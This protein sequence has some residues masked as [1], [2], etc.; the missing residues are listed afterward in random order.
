MSRNTTKVKSIC[1]W[2]M[3]FSV[4]LTGFFGVSASA[5]GG[6]YNNDDS[7]YRTSLD[8]V[9]SILTAESYEGYKEKYK[10]T[11]YIVDENGNMVPK[12][13]PEI[14][15]FGEY[16]EKRDSANHIFGSLV[17]QIPEDKINDK[18]KK[19]WSSGAIEPATELNG[20]TGNF[21]L[22]GDNS[23][24]TWTITVETSSLYNIYVEYF[25][26]DFSVGDN[27]NSKSAAAERYV[28]IDGLVP[29]K[30][31]RSIKFEKKWV[32]AYPD[33]VDDKYVY[34]ENGNKVSFK[35]DSE[36][37]DELIASG[38]RPFAVDNGGNELKPEKQIVDSWNATYLFDS[39]GYSSE[40]LSFYL[41]EGTH[42][43]SL[44]AIREPLAIKCV[45]LCVADT[46]PT[47]EEYLAKYS[48][49]KYTGEAIKVQAEF[50][51]Y[52]SSDTIYAL[53]D[54]ASSYS[55]P[56]DAALI[57]LNEIGGDKW[58]YVGQWI[59]WKVTVPE[60]GLY[61]IVPRSRQK[62]YSGMYVSRAI[63]IND[64]LPFKEAGNLRFSYS[65]DWDTKSLTS[66]KVD[67]EG[68]SVETEH[69]F[70]LKA[71]ENTIRMQ[72]VL[73]DM[74]EV[75]SRVETS[76]N[77]INKYYRKILM[78]TGPEP[79]QYRDYGFEK[80]IPDVVEGLAYESD[81][82]YAVSK[83]LEKL[84]GE[85]GEHATTLDRVAL[86]CERMSEHPDKIATELSSLKDYT[87]SL[88]TWLSD[89]QNQPLD[90]DYFSIQSAEDDDPDAEPGFF[91]SL[92][93]EIKK[94]FLSFFSDYN[95]LGATGDNADAATNVNVSVWTA[96]SRD[97]AQIL[98]TLVDDK[99][100]PNYNG[101]SVDIKLVAGGTLLPATL[102]GTGPDVYLGAAQGDPV[103]YAIR[104]AVLSLNHKTDDTKIGYN[105]NDLENSRWYTAKNEDGEYK[106][107]A[108]RELIDNGVVKE[109]DEV[110]TWFAEQAL[111]PVT[112]YGETY[113]L[114][115]TM[116]FAMMFYRKDIFVE[117]GIQVPNTWDDFYDIIYSLQ[118]NA[119]D[120]GF[121]QGTG[122]SMILMYQTIE[123][124]PEGEPLY[125]QGN[126]DYYL[127]LFRRYFY[128]GNYDEITD[129]QLAELD[130]SL[131]NK[132]KVAYY[133]EEGNI[134]PKTDGMTINLDS[135]VSLSKFKDVC[136]LFTMYDFPIQFDPAN[137]FRSGEMPLMIQDYTVYNTLII[138][139]PEINGLWEFTPLP[140]TLDEE[141]K[142]VENDTIGNISAV[143]MMNSV[144]GVENEAKAFGAWAF[145]QWYLSADVQ[146][147]YG[148][149]MVALLGPSAK[150]PTSNM[151]ALT[152]MAWSTE[153]YN[154]L[155]SQFKE[156]TC[157]PEYPGSY[158]I[159]RYT[160]FAYL[161]VVNN[162]SNP[163]DELR[164]Y[165]T[166]I[167][168]E[169]ARK[170]SE[171]GLPTADSVKEM[172]A[173]VEKNY[174]DWDEGR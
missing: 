117:L 85:K 129:D 4:L 106:Y 157:T 159:G 156:V 71:G 88:G 64:E 63:Y 72:V 11:N 80:L 82:L 96:T 21:L 153:E 46:T 13:L 170:R 111:V 39:T 158:I 139:A 38:K 172:L 171:F 154:N 31:A 69:L 3:L 75:L 163:V 40:P 10:D 94:F 167:N 86:T 155:F 146:S 87:A 33:M 147:A 128:D 43:I 100:T 83:E 97:Q 65:S 32:D 116:S 141:T 164:S 5:D 58:K 52:T 122:G 131:V 114:P 135:D 162:N 105:F 149:E 30:E 2:I 15:L 160:N 47:Y 34:D 104:S 41:S 168:V 109:L 161:D 119:L 166:D 45:K 120:I 9:E 121:P 113:G 95:N 143:M 125:D 60:A 61:D 23:T 27:L 99:F 101:I 68:N 22:C 138:F 174:P 136:N 59:E 130:A 118:S 49:N 67:E 29:Y 28:L 142:R 36:K 14:I 51:T 79:D 78:I 25:T 17:D 107:P 140:G 16:D 81:N 84:V 90:I 56:Q 57:C 66:V 44:Q 55:E 53:N 123:D 12:E 124:N 70:Y 76:L 74:A 91:G 152:N 7:M 42:T 24:V 150:Q 127:E 103:N 6:Y 137:R 110:S 54:R 165:I 92:W 98:R 173:E 108:F 8:D 1:A 133:D 151:D 145:M 134:I 35:S 37:F 77:N 48:D 62:F 115:M 112:L 19:K 20:E 93:Y 102:S 26:G 148:N 73:G 169:L 132:E 89:T 18:D 50:P 144:S 126:Y